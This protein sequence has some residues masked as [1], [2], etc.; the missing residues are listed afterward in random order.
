MNMLELRE[1]NISKMQVSKKML[2][3]N[4]KKYMDINITKES[5]Y[6]IHT[7]LSLTLNNFF[8]ASDDH[9]SVAEYEALAKVVGVDINL[10]EIWPPLE[11]LQMNPTYELP[12][13]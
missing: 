5:S 13:C 6:P 3:E 2:K 9:W 4:Y 11:Y 8:D 10:P 7:A 12:K 1:Y